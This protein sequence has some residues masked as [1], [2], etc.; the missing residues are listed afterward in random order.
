MQQR[1]DQLGKITK[2]A[3]A[4]NADVIG[5]IEVENDYANST[6]SIQ[7]GDL[8]VGHATPKAEGF[9]AVALAVLFLRKTTETVNVSV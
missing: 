6:P 9:G 8:K 5:I 3:L 1:E 7:V 2:G 4:L